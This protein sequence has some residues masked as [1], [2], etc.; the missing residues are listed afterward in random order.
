MVAE[1][2]FGHSEHARGGVDGVERA[3]GRDAP[4]DM[5]DENAGAAAEVGDSHPRPKA[6]KVE[7]IRDLIGERT[8]LSGVPSGGERVEEI[9]ILSIHK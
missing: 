4:Q 9:D 1:F 6:D 5:G 3:A 7:D 8:H 2:L